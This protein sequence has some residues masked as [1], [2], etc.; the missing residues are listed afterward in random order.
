MAGSADLSNDPGDQI[1]DCAGEELGRIEEIYFDA[2][3]NQPRWARVELD[4]LDERRTIVPL[5]GASQDADGLHIAFEKETVAQAP[6]SDAS[7]LLR[8][9][10]R[11]SAEALGPPP[12]W[13]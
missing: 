8:Y 1:R 10:E 7:A 3:T 6:V 4:A 12:D 2:A 11:F 13:P 9:Y 5:T